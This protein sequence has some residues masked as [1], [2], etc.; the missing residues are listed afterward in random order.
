MAEWQG[1]VSGR[2]NP[3][4]GIP[5]IAL[6]A[7]SGG[8]TW[9]SPVRVTADNG[10]DYFVKFAE[11]CP[12]PSQRMSIVIEMVVAN[13]GRAI[14]A[15][16]VQ[17][18]VIKVPLELKGQEIKP[19]VAISSDYA[20]ASLA[21]D[22]CDEL[23]RPNLIARS[24][25]DN[26]RRHAGIYALFDWFMG[27]DQQW[28]YDINDDR[29]IH[30]HDH[31]LYLPPLNEGRW[32]VDALQAHVGDAHVLPDDPAGLAAEA[33]AAVSK[34][35]RELTRD[36]MVAALSA[37]PIGWSVTDDELDALGWFLESRAPQVADRVDALAI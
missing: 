1:L 32:T 7:S 10:N 4:D 16:V 15:P 18:T 26:S 34:R 28:L 20:H 22:Q 21:L 27:C 5:S 37:V 33:V 11:A 2:A 6:I 3:E 17:T 9:S 13:L 23:G 30:S 14:G 35:L 19:G 36:E 8:P 25:D 29:S 24:Q 12:D 31:G